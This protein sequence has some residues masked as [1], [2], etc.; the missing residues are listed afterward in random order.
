[1]IACTCTTTHAAPHQATYRNNHGQSPRLHTQA[2]SIRDL[3]NPH[4]L[5]RDL[6]TSPICCSASWFAGSARSSPRAPLWPPHQSRRSQRCTMVPRPLPRPQ[7]H[8]PRW[9]RLVCRRTNY[10]QKEPRILMP[11]TRVLVTSA[12]PKSHRVTNTVI[13]AHIKQMLAQC[14]ESQTQ[15]RRPVP[16]RSSQGRSSRPN[17][18]G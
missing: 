6:Q 4:R 7:N 9:G 16:F 18:T 15:N 8:Q 11:S 3:L 10:Y 13:P 5:H 2:V 14:A 1:M 17:E 12:K